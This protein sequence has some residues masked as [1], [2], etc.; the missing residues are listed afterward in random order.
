MAALNPLAESQNGLLR[1]PIGYPTITTRKGY[2][3]VVC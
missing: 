3:P 1:F 2:S